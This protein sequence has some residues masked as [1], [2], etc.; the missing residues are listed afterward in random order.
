MPSK[1]TKGTNKKSLRNK[2]KQTRRQAEIDNRE[3]QLANKRFIRLLKT[4][5]KTRCTAPGIDHAKKLWKL[6]KKEARRGQTC[7]SAAYKMAAIIIGAT[8]MPVESQLDKGKL[9]EEPLGPFLSDVNTL[10]KYGHPI[11][12][13]PSRERSIKLNRY[14]RRREKRNKTRKR[15]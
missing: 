7:K 5:E 10:V 1:K 11:T 9:V 14:E 13:A 2:R 4:A 3:Q 6:S 12:R 15:K 8:Y